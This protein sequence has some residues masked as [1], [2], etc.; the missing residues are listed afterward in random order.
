[1]LGV[2]DGDAHLRHRQA[3]L[4]TFT[5]R[6]LRTLE[7]LMRDVARERVDVCVRA[8]HFGGVRELA[9]PIP[10]RLMCLLLGLPIEDEERLEAWSDAAIALM[11][12]IPSLAELA[13]GALSVA[14]LEAYV[15]DRFARATRDGGE[16]L[17]SELAARVADGT[18]SDSEARGLVFQLVVA[19][20]E[21]TVGTI[22]AALRFAAEMPD[23]WTCLREQPDDIP[24]WVEETVRL[25]TPAQGNYR[26]TLH[27]VALGGTELPPGAP[28]RSV[29]LRQ[30]R[31]RRVPAPG[32]SSS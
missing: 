6:F 16:G 32:I 24:I 15:A 29:G 28:S 30:S 9:R 1:M 10:R 22:A 7:Q 23:G 31:R 2:A 19:G 26:R 4:R 5:P 25:E 27:P 17:I 14:E 11:G 12:G 8:P 13:R 3:A 21:T 20:N 18:L